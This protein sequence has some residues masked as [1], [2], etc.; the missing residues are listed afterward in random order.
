[1]KKKLLLQILDTVIEVF[2]GGGNIKLDIPC[3]PSDLQLPEIISKEPTKYEKY[4]NFRNRM[5]QR[6]KKS[7]MYSLWCDALY[8]LSL[9]NHVILFLF[10]FILNNN[11]NFKIIDYIFFLV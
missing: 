1:M 11:N 10:F 3:S 5:I 8:K 6:R 4:Q 7:E 9:A 2:N